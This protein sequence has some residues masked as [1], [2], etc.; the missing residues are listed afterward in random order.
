[1]ART[2]RSQAKIGEGTSVPCSVRVISNAVTIRI[3]PAKPGSRIAMMSRIVIGIGLN[4]VSIAVTSTFFVTRA[5][6]PNTKLQ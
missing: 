6:C 2:I 1:M 5:A 4:L 3:N